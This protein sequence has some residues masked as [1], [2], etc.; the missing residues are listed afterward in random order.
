ML[1][2]SAFTTGNL[3]GLLFG[4][5]KAVQAETDELRTSGGADP[6]NIAANNN[7][8]QISDWLTKVLVGATL[9]QVTKLPVAL[10]Y[11]SVQYGREIGK[12][13]SVFILT[14][15]S[16][17]GFLSGY[18]FTRLVLQHALHRANTVPDLE[19]VKADKKNDDAPLVPVI[20]MD[21]KK[22]SPN[23]QKEETS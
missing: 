7:L 5:P 16:A 20:I 11:F 10:E 1:A 4:I 18:L 14:G 3:L 15:F 6:R 21:D 9:T 17:T 8:V 13:A 2:F 23:V 12:P 19:K 22:P